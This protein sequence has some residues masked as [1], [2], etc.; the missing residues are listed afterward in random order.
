MFSTV[1]KEITGYF[2]KSFLLS[3][4]FPSLFFWMLNLALGLLSVGLDDALDWW[5]KLD[6]QVQG[7]LAVASLI[8]VFFTAYVLH[9]LMGQLTRFYEGRWGF[10]RAIPRAMQA[11]SKRTWKTLR[12]QEETMGWQRYLRKYVD[13]VR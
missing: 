12:E 8:W 4:F 6:G 13:P 10:L 11:R 2:G 3:V 5:G 1:L 9:I 7:F